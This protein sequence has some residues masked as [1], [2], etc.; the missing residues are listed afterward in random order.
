[1]IVVI[2]KAWLDG[3]DMDLAT[4][5]ELLPAGNTRVARDSDG[6]YLTA[7]EIDTRPAGVPFYEV[8]PVVLRRVNGLG[9]VLR[10]GYRPVRLS[11]R[12]QEGD[13]RHQVVTLGCAE[14]RVQVRPVTS[15]IN[16]QPVASPPP[17]G[18]RYAATASADAD[19]AE[20]L[21]VLGQP[22]PSNWVELYKVYEIIEHTGLLKAAMG[23]AGISANRLKLFTRTACHPDA[24]GPDARHGRSREEPPK[25]PMPIAKARDLIGTL[26]CAWMDLLATSASTGPAR[27]ACAALPPSVRIG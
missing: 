19:V 22:T 21:A 14:A 26:V 17:S 12:Y 13:R 1:L 15:L 3:H 23:V 25:H 24:A 20:A 18:P 2:V 4:L 10:A 8:A 5:A 27:C 6:F 11:G 7:A 9:R 16:G